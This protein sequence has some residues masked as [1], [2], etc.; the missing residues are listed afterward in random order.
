MVG[1]I[2]IVLF[3]FG[4][5][6]IMLSIVG[7]IVMLFNLIIALTFQN[8]LTMFVLG[9]LCFLSAFSIIYIR[10]LILDWKENINY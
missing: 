8:I 9:V 7:L 1:L 10:E 4:I 5:F 6:S 2:V 3:V